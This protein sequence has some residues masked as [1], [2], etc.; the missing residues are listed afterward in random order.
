M[1][2]SAILKYGSARGCWLYS[3]ALKARLQIQCLGVA[4]A[5]AS[6][7][8][9]A[10][11]LEPPERLLASFWAQRA[12]AAAVALPGGSGGGNAQDHYRRPPALQQ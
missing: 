10:V 12:A 4:A 7:A 1:P 5:P 6:L 2:S 8:P 9:V 3:A 11:A